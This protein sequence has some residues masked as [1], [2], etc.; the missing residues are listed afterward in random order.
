MA[1]G[2]A[3]AALHVPFEL[4]QD[5][6]F[7]IVPFV[8]RKLG[9]RLGRK[10]ALDL[11]VGTGS[12]QPKGL[13]DRIPDINLLSGNFTQTAAVNYGQLVGAIA[14]AGGGQ[15]VMFTLDPDY[16][17][18]ATWVMRMTTLGILASITDTTGRPIF[19]PF[20]ASSFDANNPMLAP[21]TEGQ[22]GQGYRPVG[23][24]VGFPVVVDQAAP[25][26]ANA[27]IAKPGA[28]LDAFISFGDH[29]QAYVVRPVQ[30]ITLLVD[31][32][33]TMAKRQIGYF[34]WAR[35]DATIQNAKAHVLLAGW[36]AA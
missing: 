23:N 10:M 12:S 14:A 36:N 18:N 19:Q 17:P 35:Q 34:T 27:S 21:G 29:S 15:G 32:Y 20:A 24:L 16:F 26:V 11:A 33:T 5:S 6:T 13:F 7:P 30:G 22:D 2:T 8:S 1:G 3:N 31:P 4:A 25:A 9:T 28:A